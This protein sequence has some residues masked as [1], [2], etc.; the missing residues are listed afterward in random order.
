MNKTIT[1]IVFVLITC[2]TLQACAGKTNKTTQWKTFQNQFIYFEY[3][4]DWVVEENQNSISVIGPQ[5]QEYYV[6]VKID[7]N[8]SIA[9][10]LEDF[11][12]TVEEQNQVELLPDFVDGGVEEI[13]IND[14]PFFERS[15]QTSFSNSTGSQS[16]FVLLSYAVNSPTL[17]V[18]ITTECPVDS[19]I[20]YK[21]TLE[22][23][24]NS[25][26]CGD[27]L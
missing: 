20:T 8:T 7:Y 2:L 12:A 15:L 11:M 24:K 21:K 17:G 19:Y 13:T 9:F 4:A 27:S 16:L 18:V 10:T 5:V 3:P 25:F 6:N 14:L 26:R 1:S 23:I 22:K